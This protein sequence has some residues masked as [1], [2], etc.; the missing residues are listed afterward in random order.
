MTRERSPAEDTAEAFLEDA[1][2][3]HLSTRL[4]GTIVR[5]NRTFEAWTG[6]ARSEMVEVRRFQELLRPGDRIYYETHYAPLLH[7]QG[8]VRAIAVEIVRTD[9]SRMPALVN[10]VL[11]R[12]D[13]GR[14]RAIWTSVFDATDRREYEDEL[15][16]ARQ[17]E[18]EIAL[19]LQ[20]SMLTGALSTTDG[21]E[22]DAVYRP[23]ESGMEAGGDWYD[24]Y[25]LEEGETIALVVG[26]VVGHGVDAAATMG[27][28][29]SVVRALSST[30]L[31]PGTL[32][33]HLDQYAGRHGVGKMCTLVYAE[34]TL[35]TGALRFACAGHPPPLLALPEEEPRFAWGGRSTPLDA[36]DLAE[37]RDEASESLPPGS[38]VVLYTDGLV[39]GR[40]RSMDDGMER[41]R[42]ALTAH[43]SGSLS[44]LLGRLIRE[45]PDRE[46]GDDICALV[47]RLA[48]A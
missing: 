9:G 42:S 44:T 2:C 40:S 14:P 3:G 5:V 31:G 39:E 1:P 15:L 23:A 34:L 38:M 46:H 43:R 30:G 25:W 48:G 45:L 37:A 17:R 47:A 41:M 18:Q 13:S 27:Q 4:D 20:R 12:D 16:R 35:A 36:Y 29:R 33:E 19:R 22:I 11:R 8:F 26:D 6:L 10:S 32:L 7:M 21:C 28:L 24:A